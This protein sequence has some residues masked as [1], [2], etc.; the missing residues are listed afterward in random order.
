[1]RRRL[2]ALALALGLWPLIAGAVTREDFLARTAQAL[3]DLCAAS[4]TDPLYKEALSFCHGYWVGAY[5]YYQVA[6]AGP[7]GRRFL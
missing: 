6:A 5:Q 3:L 2:P 1:M 7:E 4:P